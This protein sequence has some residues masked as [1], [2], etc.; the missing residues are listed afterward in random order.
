MAKAL[1]L[2]GKLPAAE[3]E[4]AALRKTNPDF[5]ELHRI[6]GDL[7]WQKRD[8]GRARAEYARA[9]ALDSSSNLALTGLIEADLAEKK[10]AAARDRVE[11]K[12]ASGSTDPE[13][14]VVA[15]VTYIAAGDAKKAE[16]AFRKALELDPTNLDGYGR[17][18]ALYMMTNRVDAAKAEYERMLNGKPDAVV[19]ARTMLGTI[20]GM[21]GKPDEAGKQYEQA[22]ATDPEAAVAANNLAWHYAASDGPNL[23]VA[24]KLAQTAKRKLPKSWEATD[25]LGWIYYKKGLAD[26]AVTTLREAVKQNP[27]IATLH[28][29]LGLAYMKGGSKRDAQQSLEQALE[30]DPKFPEAEE[31]RR[32]LASVKG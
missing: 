5:P 11:A 31:A 6:S 22:L 15:G 16:S 9:L 1:V 24:L 26:L 17:L 23:D 25:T 19:L 32:A 27:S 10:I 14:F 13:F 21:Q 28:Y 8:V 3:A 7:A 4:L 30:L 20:Y 29:H 2:Q 18:G 12:L